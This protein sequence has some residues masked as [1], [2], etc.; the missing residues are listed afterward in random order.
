MGAAKYMH[1]RGQLNVTGVSLSEQQVNWAREHLSVPGLRFIF[2]DYRD[3]CEDPENWG[4]YDRVYSIGMLEHVGYKNY[5]SLFQCIKTLLK[6][7]GLAVVHTIGEP[8][9]VPSAD[10][11]L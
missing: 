4:T 6:P 9:F 2:S 5:E 10:P 3:H 7:D 8:D 11:W 1:D